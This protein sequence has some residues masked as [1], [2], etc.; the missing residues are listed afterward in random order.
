[1]PFKKIRNLKEIVPAI[2]K[3]LNLISLLCL[4]ALVIIMGYWMIFSNLKIAD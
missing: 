3:K 4:A 1:M 2:Q